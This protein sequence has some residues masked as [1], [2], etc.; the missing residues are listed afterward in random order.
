MEIDKFITISYT[1]YSGILIM[2]IMINHALPTQL[3]WTFALED[4]K[5]N[6]DNVKNSNIRFGFIFDITKIGFISMTYIKEFIRVIENYTDMLESKLYATSSVAQGSIIKHIFDLIN[7][8][9]KTKKPL[10]I[11]DNRDEALLFIKEHKDS[12]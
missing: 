3:Q 4:L 5:S 6:L 7:L 1:N 10:K 8:F 9:Y 11:V 12:D 2:E